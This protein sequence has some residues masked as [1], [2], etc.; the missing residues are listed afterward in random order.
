MRNI[1]DSLLILTILKL[2]F[3]IKFNSKICLNIILYADAVWQGS[4]TV[5]EN[6]YTLC[7]IYILSNSLLCITKLR[8]C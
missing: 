4:V 7:E 3:I 6:V 1:V 8:E 2:H 5:Q